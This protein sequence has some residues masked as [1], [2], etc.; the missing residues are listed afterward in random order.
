MAFKRHVE[1][2]TIEDERDALRAQHAALEDLKRELAERV[3]AVRE[4][5]LELQHV[6]AEAGGPRPGVPTPAPP[7]PALADVEADTGEDALEAERRERE[8][9]EREQVVAAR[10]VELA[11]REVEL[12]TREQDLE[13]RADQIAALPPADPDAARLAQIEVRLAELR[14]A[15]KLFARTRD[16][17]APRSEAVAARERL[18]A[19]R[20]RELDDREDGK[21]QWAGPEISEVEARLR[22]LEQRQPGEQTLG[23]SGGLRKLEQG[24]R[25]QRGG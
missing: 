9:L 7:A 11:A 8:L 13:T 14:D 22:R 1:P 16:E 10:E 18:V 15:E 19:Q 17:L 5:E 12:A 23:F 24:T 2:I 6:L 21:G 3:D 4:R 20:E 25:S